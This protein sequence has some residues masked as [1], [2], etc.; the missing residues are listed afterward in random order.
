[1]R[2]WRNG[3]LLG[4]ALAQGA[5]CAHALPPDQVFERAEPGVWSLRLLGADNVPH[6]VGSAV[7]IAAG[8]AVTSCAQVPRGGRLV[9]MKAKATL[10][11]TLEFTDAARDLCQLDVPGLQ[12]PEPARAAPRMGLRVYAIG[13]ER[14]AELTIGEGLVARI[15]EAGSDGERIQ[16]NMPTTG[17]LQGAGLFDD[18]ARLLGVTTL[19]VRDAPGV[20][21]AAPARWLA[22][23]AA[24]GSAAAS[25]RIAP[26]A[27]LP[28]PGATWT[29]S[30]E[31]RG[32]GAT[33]ATFVVR[34]TAV[35]ADTVQESVVIGSAPAQRYTV[36]ADAL[37]FRSIALPRSQT[38]PELAPYLHSMLARG[39]ERIWGKLQGYPRGSVSMPPWRLHVRELGEEQVTVPAGTFKAVRIDVIGSRNAPGAT[40]PGMAGEST[41]FQFKVWY[42]PEVRR[43]VKLQHET[44][45]MRRDWS[46]EQV[47]QLLSFSE[48]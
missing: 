41:S 14:G 43:Y 29:Y 45:A 32:L 35:E 8:K 47:V 44:T 34:A 23:I 27:A 25:T 3:L 9:L 48:K 22:E 30:Y 17:W 5:L 19:S 15:R 33:Q 13:Y 40:L 31:S 16:T 21:I 36:G 18:E 46:G 4:I 39:E 7:A 6:A 20:V 37:A 10:P 11:A 26:S 38:L 42:V 28:Q 1:M 2:Q 12:A 24:R